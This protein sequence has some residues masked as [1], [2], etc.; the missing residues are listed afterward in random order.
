M[1]LKRE[2]WKLAFQKAPLAR[3]TALTREELPGGDN[4]ESQEEIHRDTASPNGCFAIKACVCLGGHFTLLTSERSKSKLSSWTSE[5]PCFF[6]ESSLCC[7]LPT[8][9][10]FYVFVTRRKG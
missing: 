4:L 3:G 8:S 1:R 6:L 5:K 9:S 7:Q 2:E 10:P